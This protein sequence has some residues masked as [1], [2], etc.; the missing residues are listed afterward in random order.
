MVVSNPETGKASLL[1]NTFDCAEAVAHCRLRYALID[2]LTRLCADLAYSKGARSVP[3]ADLL[4]VPAEA[5]WIEWCNE[6]WQNALRE[7]GFHAELADDAAH[8]VGR[9]GAW[10]RS[11][12]DGRRGLIRTFWSATAEDVLASSV[13]AYFD[14]DTPTDE[15]PEPPD[16]KEGLAEM[17]MDLERAQDDVLSRCFRFRY[18]ESWSGRAHASTMFADTWCGAASTFFGG[19]PIC[20]A[21]PASASSDPGQ[22][23]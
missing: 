11:S 1:N 22:S 16:G 14:F 2:N 8:W 12:R 19:C 10:I 23:F 13:E 20:E 7:Y 15:A 17:V 5:L 9:R 3:C 4:R 21:A 18:E 6:P